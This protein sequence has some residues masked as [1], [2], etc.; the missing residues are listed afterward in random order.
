MMKLLF[1][2]EKSKGK[3]K[4]K[5]QGY[6]LDSDRSGSSTWKVDGILWKLGCGERSKQKYVGGGRGGK[7]MHWHTK[8][9]KVG[10]R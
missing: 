1:I 2:H 9:S 7:W 5:N 4:E 6:V 3:I 8:S 10:T